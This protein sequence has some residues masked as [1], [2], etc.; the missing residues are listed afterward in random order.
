MQVGWLQME[1][2]QRSTE[3]EMGEDGDIKRKPERPKRRQKAIEMS[4]RD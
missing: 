1:E 3:T 4:D 2:K